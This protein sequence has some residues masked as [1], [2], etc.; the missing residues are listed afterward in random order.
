MEA[1][2]F[3]LTHRMKCCR[4][5]LWHQL[6]HSFVIISNVNH[7][8]NYFSKAFLHRFQK[9]SFI[10]MEFLELTVIS[11]HQSSLFLNLY[12]K[13]NSFLHFEWKP[14]KQSKSRSCNAALMWKFR[15]NL[16]KWLEKERYYYYGFPPLY[17]NKMTKPNQTK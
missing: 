3:S 11:D 16:N 2:F 17:D 1:T 14:R 6:E 8:K 5:A 4:F 15:K 13:P 10:S 12:K 9:L 7:S